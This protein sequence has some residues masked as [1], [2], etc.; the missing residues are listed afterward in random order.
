MFLS[1]KLYRI[2]VSNF[3]VRLPTN[4]IPSWF[5][6]HAIVVQLCKYLCGKIKETWTIDIKDH[7][8]VQIGI[9]VHMFSNVSIS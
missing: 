3:S 1:E 9:L 2:T 8:K 5:F 7:F 6:R 4:R